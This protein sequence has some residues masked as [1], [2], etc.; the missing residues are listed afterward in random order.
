MSNGEVTG[1]HFKTRQPV[2]LTWEAGKLTSIATAT[3]A[4]ENVWV[5]P[6]LTDL[7]VNG[8]GS[9]CFQ[10]PAIAESDLLKA[11]HAMQRDACGQFLLTI[12]TNVWSTI[13]D[14]IRHVRKLR[15]QNSELQAAIPGFHIEGPFMSPV[16]GF[17]GAHSSELMLS[18]TPEHIRQLREAAGNDPVLLTVAPERDGV[19]EA[20]K[21]ATSL[22]IVISLGHTNAPLE[23]IQQ[24]VKNGARSF[25]HLGNGCPQQL[26]RHDNILWRVMQTPGLTVGLIV[27]NIHVSTMLLNIF[28]RAIDNTKMW[29]TTDAVAP[30][31]APPGTYRFG[32]K[33]FVVGADQ[34]V[35]EPGKTNFAGSAL[36]PIEGIFRAA[37]MLNCP[38]QDTWVRFSEQPRALMNMNIDQLQSGKPADLCVIDMKNDSLQTYIRGELRSTLPARPRLEGAGM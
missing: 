21:L 29:Y 14:Q 9:V 13:L 1:R 5:A 26:D 12:V 31:G 4:P 11:V 15:A 37:Q 28:H 10:T 34:V 22:G 2:R 32:G 18:P 30:A 24:A 7:Q 19:L 8:Y 36:R 27:D 23:T 25:T 6:T 20:I 17:V 33:D 3:S 35:R 16:P 38:W